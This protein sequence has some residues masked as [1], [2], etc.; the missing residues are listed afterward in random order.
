LPYL[1]Y[2]DADNSNMLDLIDLGQFRS[3]FNANLF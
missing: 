3:R 2:L 1:A